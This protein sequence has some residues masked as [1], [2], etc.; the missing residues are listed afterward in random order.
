MEDTLN[1]KEEIIT[2]QGENI[3]QEPPV[4]DTK[5]AEIAAPIPPENNDDFVP[6]AE[7][8]QRNVKPKE[9]EAP[10][11]NK[12]IE[13]V[14]KWKS[15]GWESEDEI[16]DRNE[17]ESIRKTAKTLDLIPD[18]VAAALHIANKKGTGWKEA[19][20]EIESLVKTAE[21][22]RTEV[23]GKMVVDEDFIYTDEA[24]NLFIEGLKVTKGAKFDADRAERL[25]NKAQEDPDT[26]IETLEDYAEKINES[27]QKQLDSLFKDIDTG[28]RKE[29]KEQQAELIEREKKFE[30]Y[31]KVVMETLNEE[32]ANEKDYL[33][34]GDKEKEDIHFF[35]RTKEDNDIIRQ[36]SEKYLQDTLE[37][38]KKLFGEI[39]KLD[40]E[41][42]KG[43]FEGA[44]KASIDAF[45][46]A[47]DDR[48]LAA[49]YQK[50]Q[51][52]ANYQHFK[53][54]GAGATP[55]IQ[56]PV[57]QEVIAANREKEGWRFDER[58]QTYVKAKV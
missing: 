57:S 15:K 11:D 25:Y 13:V 20:K 19:W 41:M 2:P 55:N 6:K 1:K 42:K 8:K 33:T 17:V 14:P 45:K 51:E 23:D 35:S 16:I 30:N 4:V 12:P 22:P 9:G 52:D 58:T 56:Q 34:I 43:L 21:I 27:K 29:A 47:N 28:G 40:A 53:K 26:F 7:I 3:Q 44:K 36:S 10:I 46:L 31:S 18:E 48:R 5:A 39:P 49:A 37:G 50:G 54:L 38:W 32:L 24:K